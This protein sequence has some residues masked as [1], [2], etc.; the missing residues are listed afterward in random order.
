MIPT[1]IGQ[2]HPGGH[3]AG[4][5]RIRNRCYAVIISRASSERPLPVKTDNSATLGAGSTIDGWA[6]T[7]AMCD[8]DHPA[9]AYCRTLEIDGC[10]D[11]Y[12]PSKNELEICYRNLKP[13]LTDNITY[14]AD[15]NIRPLHYENGT[16]TSS[17]PPGRPYSNSDPSVTLVLCFK[18]VSEQVR[19]IGEFFTKRPYH[20]STEL[21]KS[22]SF[23]VTQVFDCGFQDYTFKAR[24]YYL[25]RAV[26]R[27]LIV[28]L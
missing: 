17:I 12:L 18:R 5:N 26:R 24:N 25:V 13:T 23:S 6:N 22:I 19:S 1:R 14:I 7:Q 28:E 4:V 9:A 8:S 27:Q 10:A 16:N 11:F 15:W 20:S 2:V 21:T 3:F